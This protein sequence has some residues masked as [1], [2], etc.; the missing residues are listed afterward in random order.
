MGSAQLWCEYGRRPSYGARYGAV[1]L[2]DE[3]PIYSVALK[4]FLRLHNAK[5]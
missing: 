3:M 1:T 5:G 2:A 4:F